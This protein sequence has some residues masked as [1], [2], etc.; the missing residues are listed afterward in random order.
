M[1]FF[2]YLFHRFGVTVENRRGNRHEI[3][4]VAL[5]GLFDREIGNTSGK[6]GPRAVSVGPSGRRDLGRGGVLRGRGDLISDNSH[7]KR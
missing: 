6:G 4:Q 2:D 1:S 3:P 5:D 7:L